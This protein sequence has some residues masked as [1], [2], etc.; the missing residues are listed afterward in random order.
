M[1]V[2]SI[3]RSRWH[4]TAA[5]IIGYLILWQV[6][7]EASAAFG[8]AAG[9]RPWFPPVALDVLLLFVVG[10][11]WWPLLPVAATVH[12]LIFEPHHTT[13]N[14]SFTLITHTVSA[15]IYATGAWYARDV[16]HLRRPLR[17][18]RDVAWFCGIFALAAP[19]IAGSLSVSAMLVLHIVA[20]RDVYVQLTRFI[21]GDSAAII[22][23]VPALLAALDWNNLGA[24]A[25]HR[26]PKPAEIAALVGVTV[27][28]VAL[29]YAAAMPAPTALLDLSFVSIAWLSIRYGMRGAI[30]AIVASGLTSSIVAVTL[31]VPVGTLVEFQ[32]FLI[33]STLMAL[34]LGSLTVER[35]D[36]VAMLARRAYIDDLT[37]LPNRE[38]LVQWIDM[39]RD[40]ALVLV[41]FDIDEM[42]LL[43]EGVGRVAADRALQDIALRMRA[44]LPTSY[45]VAR[46]SADEYA[47]AVVDER[48]P[49]AIMAEVR[50]FFDLPFEVEGARIFVSVS[51]GALRVARGGDPDE[52]LRR[53][54]LAVHRAKSTP[55]RSVVYTPELLGSVASLPVGQLHRAVE[56][57]ELVSFYQPIFKFDAANDRWDV[58]GA[59]SLLRWM[60]PERGV[61]APASFID[62]LERL[63]ISEHVGWTVVETSLRQAAEWRKIIPGFTVWVNLFARQALDRHCAR[64]IA[65]LLERNNIP[66]EAL[67]IEIN[68]RIVASD[69]R[70]VAALAI[71]LRGIGVQT[72][73]DDFGTGGSS[74]GRVREVPASILKIDRSFVAKSEVD[75][76]AK[77]VASTV[78]R[79]ATELGMGVVAEGVENPMQLAVMIETGCEYAQ[80]YALGHP[81]PADLFEREFLNLSPAS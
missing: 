54:D 21:V 79:L 34:L 22:V 11:R 25:E 57:R 6:L 24:P 58:V 45:F 29:G 56:K 67:V 20:P 13:T 51:M 46:V 50:Q 65:D 68:E 1:R 69:E 5:V 80:G 28:L 48:S 52:M 61:L 55:S 42:R 8:V 10:W 23:I 64:R 18:S 49:H 40:S 70:D 3:L 9:F 66:P 41:M 76:K 2:Q 63:T 74:L 75:A 53:V 12:W 73:I 33:A 7:D 27:A 81:L 17:A 39:H 71:A 72:A 35:W 26:N 31:H 4:R 44:G 59:E 47:V 60:H 14:L 19:V 37:G 30:L 62:L 36:L 78:V 16:L 15:L 32:A 38:R 43:N 77:A